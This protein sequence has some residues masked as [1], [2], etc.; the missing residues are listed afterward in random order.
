MITIIIQWNHSPLATRDQS[1]CSNY[2]MD[3]LGRF[4]VVDVSDVVG[5]DVVVGVVV[6]FCSERQPCGYC[7]LESLVVIYLPFSD[8]AHFWSFL[9]LSHL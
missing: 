6:G 9:R 7:L 3:A 1:K 8:L 5:V 2:N 4:A